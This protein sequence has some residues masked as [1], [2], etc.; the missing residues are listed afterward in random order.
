MHEED[1]RRTR[2][3]QVWIRRVGVGQGV[4]EGAPRGAV[5]LKYGRRGRLD[6][7]G[8]R[9]RSRS[10][11]RFGRC[12][13]RGRAGRAAAGGDQE[14]QAP[15]CDYD[16][17]SGIQPT[18]L[19]RRRPPCRGGHSLPQGQR[20]E[21]PPQPTFPCIHLAKRHFNEPWVTGRCPAVPLGRHGDRCRELIATPAPPSSGCLD[22]APVAINP[23]FERRE[24]L[25]EGTAEVSEPTEG[26]SFDAAGVEV[27]G[28]QSVAFGSPEGFGEHL[29]ETPSSA[30]SRSW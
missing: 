1:G 7:R 12:G 20:G 8:G 14:R 24:G 22:L 30:S 23:P 15:N 17:C 3:C 11:G 10:G 5:S 4:L 13:R 26:G 25:V 6:R 19:H 29:C 2:R 9:R 16:G 28:G 27:A 18:Q 21:G